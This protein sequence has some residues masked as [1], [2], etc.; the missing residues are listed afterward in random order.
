MNIHEKTWH[1]YFK[2]QTEMHLPLF[3]RSLQSLAV[4]CVLKIVC[5]FISC[6][7]GGAGQTGWMTWHDSSEPN[8]RDLP[9]P[10]ITLLMP[11]HFIEWQRKIH[12][13]MTRMRAIEPK[14]RKSI[15][16][17]TWDTPTD[18]IFTACPYINILSFFI[19][20]WSGV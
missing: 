9:H 19:A 1:F 11:K 2:M 6:C 16:K 8:P 14:C 15:L 10:T 20:N 7:C 17:D 4:T 13:M 3:P 18:K 5:G 12:H